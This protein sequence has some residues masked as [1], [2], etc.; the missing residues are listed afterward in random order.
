MHAS[1][2]R[3]SPKR[4]LNTPMRKGKPLNSRRRG[5]TMPTQ[6][7]RIV[8]MFYASYIRNG[9]SYNTSG[10]IKFLLY[11]SPMSSSRQCFPRNYSARDLRALA[12]RQRKATLGA[13]ACFVSVYI[14]LLRMDVANTS[15]L[16]LARTFLV[17]LH[18]LISALSVVPLGVEICTECLSLGISNFTVFAFTTRL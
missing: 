7:S 3:Q 9:D 18:D 13:S 4:I 15:A 5:S 1:S 8:L 17:P 12:I 10:G 2:V 14:C 16:F 11:C 6:W